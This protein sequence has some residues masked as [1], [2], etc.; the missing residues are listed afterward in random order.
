MPTQ[1]APVALV[2]GASAGTGAEIARA[3]AAAGH[4]VAVVANRRVAELETLAREIGD[5]GRR[6]LV[7]P[8]DLRDADA[9]GQG[10]ARF[11]Q[12]SGGRCDVLVNAAGITGPL[13]PEI[14]GF[15]VTAFDEV[16]AV[17]LRAPF[18]LLTLLLPVMRAQGH[19][20]VVNIG[21]NHGMRGRA[22]RSSYSASKWG[23]R[24]LS[25]S[26][27]LEAGKNNV[28]VNYIAPGPI[29]VQR[30]KDGWAARAAAEGKA[31]DDLVREYVSDMGIALGKPNEP[32]D[33]VATVMFLVGPGGRNITGQEFV[34]DGGVIV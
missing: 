22:G 1:Q 3:L 31:Y 10:V 27:A 7:L 20:R 26:A 6:A 24:G 14:G 16:I 17:N 21:G 33:I 19:G 5:M 15:D 2:T 28:T 18:A 8:I 29:A 34:I 30:M 25:R 11:L 9:I 23:L 12:W 32:A 13:S 4:D